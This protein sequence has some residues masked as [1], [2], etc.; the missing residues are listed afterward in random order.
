M[1]R[2]FEIDENVTGRFNQSKDVFSDGICK[3]QLPSWCFVGHGCVS[4][5]IPFQ[6]NAGGVERLNKECSSVGEGIVF[7]FSVPGSI[8]IILISSS[9]G[10]DGTNN[11]KSFLEDILRWVGVGG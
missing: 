6:N 8:R 4:T 3:R 1:Q 2:P 9:F 7:F 5:K 11:G 10:H